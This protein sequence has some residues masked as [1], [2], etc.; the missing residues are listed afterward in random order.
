[1]I[2]RA[3]STS[4]IAQA[5]GFADDPFPGDP[6]RGSFVATEAHDA[7]LATVGAWIS[8]VIAEPA[9]Q[10]RL[11][12]VTGEEGSGKSMLL[13]EIERTLSPAGTR[14]ARGR[15]PT[16]NRVVTIPEALAHR[17]DAQL[18]KGILAAFGADPSGRTGLELRGELRAVLQ[19]LYADDVR[20]GL[21]IDGAH[22]KGSQLE[23][24]RNLLRDAD[25]T[26]LWIVLFGLPDLHDRMQRR[27]SLRGLTG[28]TVALGALSA[29][30]I[31]RLVNG[32]ID[33]VRTDE[34]PEVIF[35]DEARPVL[36]EWAEGNASR[37]VRLAAASLEVAAAQG[38]GAVTRG[39]VQGVG[40]ELTIADAHAAWE[41]PTPGRPV[42]APMP[43]FDEV[44]AGASSA[45]TQRALWG[46][47]DPA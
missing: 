14:R 1:M 46:E 27:R 7:A 12:L 43:L 25:G 22:F 2:S 32:R 44:P 24:V 16:V 33:A 9:R 28:A 18:L 20:P 42:Q 34:T 5:F 4:R 23:L 21:L 19:E 15:R 45:T 26:G 31:D 38:G 11:G 8:E 6:A 10:D 36:R 3:S 41:E 29:A 35:G 40:R 13:A 39:L 17:S 30:D 37:L 47:E